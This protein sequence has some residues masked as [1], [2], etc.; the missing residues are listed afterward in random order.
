MTAAA[1]LDRLQGVRQT[2]PDRWLARCPSHSDTAPS[3][4]I[5]ETDEGIVLLRCFAGC[6]AADVVTAVG[7][8]LRDLFPARPTKHYR[9]PVPRS[10]RPYLT[11]RELADVLRHSTLV[12]LAA[13]QVVAQGEALPPEDMT[14]LHAAAARLFRVLGVADE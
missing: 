13:A 5:R 7:L 1:L 3:L 4:S 2:Q 12:V 9:G 11:L 8:E 10:Q 14:T 6:L